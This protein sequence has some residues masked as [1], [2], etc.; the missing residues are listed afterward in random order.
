MF[1]EVRRLP[2]MQY[3]TAHSLQPSLH[4]EG[5]ISLHEPQSRRLSSEHPYETFA[6]SRKA[7]VE[8]LPAN[9]DYLTKRQ[10]HFLSN[11]RMI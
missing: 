2:A 1:H 3:S 11:Y 6:L 10:R 7:G 8:L 9:A 5:H 4:T